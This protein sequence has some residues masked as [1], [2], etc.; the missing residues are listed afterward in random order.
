T[1]KSILA[2]FKFDEKLKRY[3]LKEDVDLSYRISKSHPK[4]LYITPYAKVTHNVSQEGRLPK[5]V[6]SEMQEIY[7][8]YFFYKN[9]DQTLKNKL[10]HLWNIIGKMMIN[11]FSLF[12]MPSKCR[13]FRLKYQIGAYSVCRKHLSEIKNG[14]LEFFNKQLS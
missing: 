1:K 11:I 12:L 10:I 2:K 6:R 4:S 5:R 13:F 14:D 8:L 7:T 3:S 9:I